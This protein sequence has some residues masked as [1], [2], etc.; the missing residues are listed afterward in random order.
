MSRKEA[1]QVWWQVFC[2]FFVF[3]VLHLQH[4]K[5][6]RLGVESEQQLLG[7]TKATATATPYLSLVYHLHHSSP[8]RWILNPLGLIPGLTQWVGDLALL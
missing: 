1:G 6:P 5:V 3:L 8:Q 4:M 7:Y 2:L